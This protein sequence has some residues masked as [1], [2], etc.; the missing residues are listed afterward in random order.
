[1]NLP[2][3]GSEIGLISNSDIRF[4]GILHSIN[5]NDSTVALEQ[6]K[7]F[8]TEDR[9]VNDRIPPSDQIFAYIVF[10]GSDIKDLYVISGPKEVYNGLPPGMNPY[11]AQQAMAFH[12]QQQQQYWQQQ[13]LGYNLNN[14]HMG[15]MDPNSMMSLPVSA[16]SVQGTVPAAVSAPLHVPVPSSNIV[17]APAQSGIAVAGKIK[18]RAQELDIYQGKED[19][20]KKNLGP[21]V[22][23]NEN[24]KIQKNDLKQSSS[25]NNNQKNV[26]KRE[27]NVTLSK[28]SNL[29]GK[30]TVSFDLPEKPKERKDRKS[31]V[32]IPDSEFDFTSSNAKFDKSSIQ[33]DSNTVF[34]QKSSFFDNISSEVKDRSA[35]IDRKKRV[36]EEKS[37]NLETFGTTGMRSRGRGRGRGRS[38]RR[39]QNGVVNGS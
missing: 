19:N 1:M 26:E 15:M 20:F 10:K 25:W 36:T 7:S 5:P 9:R 34:Y 2:F 38:Y 14:A 24:T 16:M 32:V 37:Q 28:N 6:V 3:V 31:K 18:T 27:I 23:K 4:Q 13:N 17:Q 29:T 39:N 21:S 22:V 30:N 8:G 35:G 33:E 12:Q 11:Y